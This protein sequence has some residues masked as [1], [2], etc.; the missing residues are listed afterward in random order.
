M[1]SFFTEIIGLRLIHQTPCGK[2]AELRDAS[3]FKLQIRQF[4]GSISQLQYGYSPILN[5][6]IHQNQDLE[7]IV[8]KACDKK[9][10]QFRCH[11]D[12][13]IIADEYLKIV[14][15]KLEESGGTGGGGPTIAITQKLQEFEEEKKYEELIREHGASELEKESMLDPKE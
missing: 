11:L 12:G 9:N 1:S 8:E 10:S 2:F 5:F 6:E 15:L 4:Q 7:E 14:C 3:G 13:D